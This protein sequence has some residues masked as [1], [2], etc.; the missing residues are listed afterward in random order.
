MQVAILQS[1]PDLSAYVGEILKTW[2]L[3]LFD[4]VRPD[5]VSGLEPATTPVVIVPVCEI[6]PR[7]AE[8]LVA[9]A[10]RGGMVVSFLPQG[11]LASAAGLKSEG[12]KE[13][14]LRL[15]LSDCPVVGHAGELLPIVGRAETWQ[16]SPDAR[17]LAHLS[18]P[19][20]YTGESVGIVET[21]LGQ[22][23]IVA[24]AF[25]LALCVLMLRQ[26]DPARAEFIPDGDGCARPCHLAADIGPHDSGWVPYADL[27]SRLLVDLVRVRLRAPA[28]MLWHLPDRAHGILLYSGDEDNSEVAANDAEMN[29]LAAVGAR[30]NLYMIPTA[31]K[32]TKED[33][34]RYLAHHDLGP[35]PNLRPLD[36]SSVAERLREFERQILMF[37]EMFGAPARSL[38]NHCTAWAGYL[39]PVEVMEKLGIRMD[40]NYFSGSY[41]RDRDGS[42]YGMFGSAM[43]M[44]FCRT[45][46][47]L[48]NVFQQ[49][50]HLADDS[51]FGYSDYSYRISAQQFE[52][53]LHRIFTD[54]AARFHT[55]YA[56]CIHPGNWVRFSRPQGKELLRQAAK[57]E[58]PIWSFDQWLDF[59]EARDS[60]RFRDV[61]W[62]GADL[63][64]VAE[65][66]TPHDALSLN[67]PIEHAGLGLREVWFGDEKAAWH[68]HMRHRESVALAALPAGETEFRVRA[69]YA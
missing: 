66:H 39:E 25:D 21:Q 54:I 35:H 59:W 19:G 3:P 51:M 4:F 13:V 12:E 50:V 64:F 40:A 38:R 44:R 60:W 69:T 26:G 33:V 30:M 52:I 1:P 17:V 53:V 9:Y 31:T 2:G 42:P 49:H 62:N 7:D 63:Q 57:R 37:Q 58:L 14:P 34:R 18:H 43:P 16:H 28:P 55:P 36:G 61:R 8:S 32:S 23:R 48:L 10:Q 41:M 20:R 27:L 67:L 47:R 6:R 29:E 11:A 46:G 15:R 56:V 22:G 45:D 24:V 65:G 68:K 5:A